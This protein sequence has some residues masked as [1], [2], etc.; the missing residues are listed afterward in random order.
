MNHS[1]RREFLED[2]GRGMLMTGVGATLAFELGLAS[3]A[4]ADEEAK[5]LDFGKFEPLAALLQETPKDKLLPMLAEKHKTGTDLRTLTAAAALANARTFGGEDYFGFH[6]FMALAPAYQMAKESPKDEQPL[7]IWKV[8]YRNAHYTERHGGRSKDVLHQIDVPKK[9]LTAEQVRAA[10]NSGNG[11]EA[12][13]ALAAH[14]QGSA[15]EMLNAAILGVEDNHDVHSAVMPWRAWV[16]LDFV[17]KDHALTMLRQSVRQT[18][19]RCADSHAKADE[20]AQTRKL[21]PSLLEQHKLLKGSHGKRSLE[22]AQISELCET[23]LTAGPDQAGGA[24]ATALAEGYSPEQVGEAIS[25][26]ANQ[27]VLRQVENW[28]GVYGTR[29][30]GD[31]PGVHMSDETNAW[32]NMA[33]VANARNRA[34][35]LI[36]A[37]I[38]IAR[39][40]NWSINRKPSPGHQKDPYPM[41]EHLRDV[42]RGDAESLLKE[43]E[44]A[45]QENRQLRAC[46]IV[47]NYAQAGFD[48]KAVFAKLRTYAISEDGRLHNEKFYRTV[49]EEFATI[50]PSFRWRQ[51]MALARVT[52]SSYGYS[53]SDKKEGRAP[54]YEESRRLLGI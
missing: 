50:R 17:G 3:P 54:G 34:A 10:V 24:V 36:L 13:R 4:F 42:K 8:L 47:Q 9:S 29:T 1:H 32:R 6:T 33:R 15:E 28:N 11:T 14:A 40:W 20:L 27:L 35:G 39:H 31:S 45:V 46:A 30:H 2:V 38:D 48:P 23:I 53:Q 7:P 41:A 52:A 5:P 49:V 51:L 16:M 12:E 25:L 37:A 21:L 18:A 44:G 19:K 43:L 26:A 22:D